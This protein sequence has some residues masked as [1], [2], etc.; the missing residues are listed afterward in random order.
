MKLFGDFVFETF[1]SQSF[2]MQDTWL[3]L[4]YLFFLFLFKLKFYSNHSSLIIWCSFSPN[5]IPV[6]RWIGLLSEQIGFARNWNPFF[7]EPVNILL[8]RV[9]I[10]DY[11]RQLVSV[12]WRMRVCLVAEWRAVFLTRNIKLFIGKWEPR[13]PSERWNLTIFDRDGSRNN[14]DN[15][16]QP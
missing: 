8:C 9:I 13:L 15:L 2:L 10:E 7:L 1:F 5:L 4:H 12:K 6:E 3:V 16:L 14:R 11:E